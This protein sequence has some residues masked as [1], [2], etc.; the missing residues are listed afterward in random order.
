ML[1]MSIEF[2]SFHYS[3][4]MASARIYHGVPGGNTIGADT[5]LRLLAPHKSSTKVKANGNVVPLL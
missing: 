3:Y 1:R 2:G 4:K 5:S